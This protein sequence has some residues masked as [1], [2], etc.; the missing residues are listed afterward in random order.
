[1]F[2]AIFPLQLAL[3]PGE[4]APLHIFEPRYR[5]LIAECRDEGI[6]FGIPSYVE[7]SIS[8]YGT[9]V[10]LVQILHVHDTGEMD[11]VVRGIRVF[12]VDRVI[13][14]VPDKLYSGAEISWVENDSTF[15]PEIQSDLIAAYE[16]L[17]DLV[18][19]PAAA[20]GG[21]TENLSFKIGP[22]VNLTLVQRV[23]LLAIP[24]ERDRQKLLLDHLEKLTEA[25]REEMEKRRIVGG[26]GRPPRSGD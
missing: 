20:Y 8:R 9:E 2:L 3:F 6:T 10:E 23:N 19:H 24:A 22:Q 11:I 12:E 15:D 14:D 25:V 26:N 1:M 16:G 18:G 21:D 13:T 7:G 4:E 17:L 5:Q